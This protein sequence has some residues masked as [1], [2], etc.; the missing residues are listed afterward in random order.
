MCAEIV[1]SNWTRYVGASC[2]LRSPLMRNIRL[3][4]KDQDIR[5]VAHLDILGMSD[6]VSRNLDEAWGMLSDLVAVRD[7]VNTLALEFTDTGDT[8]TIRD[9]IKIV[10]FSDTIILFTKTN[11]QSELRAMI[12]LVAEMFHKAIVS[13]VPVR[14]G[15][16][17]GKFYF[18]DLKSM[19][20]GPAL[21]EAY[22]VG[23]RSQWLGISLADSVKDAAIEL[24]M[25]S[26]NSEVVVNWDIPCKT[27]NINGCAVNWP[28]LFAHDLRV[29]PPISPEGFYAA[30]HSISG[31]YD[32][33]PNSVKSKY[34]NTVDFMN[35]FLEKHGKCL[36][37]HSI[38]VL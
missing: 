5:Y 35:H 11:S 3:N 22:R 2:R 30:F 33:L 18:N 31:P 29:A 20:A 26:K 6:L 27:G 10:T 7:H 4:M 28:A 24:R 37:N 12:V 9:A 8:V 15:I 13:C 16:S 32:E 1:A 17:L 21:I 34:I 36:T 38:S 25:A 23:E 19:Y 14:V